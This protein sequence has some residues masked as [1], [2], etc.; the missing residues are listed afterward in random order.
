MGRDGYEEYVGHTVSGIAYAM[1]PAGKR[2]ARA[3]RIRAE[4]ASISMKARSERIG[5]QSLVTPLIPQ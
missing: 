4:R 2:A 5:K 3:R 1:F